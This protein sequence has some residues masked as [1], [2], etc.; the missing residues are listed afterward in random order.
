MCHNRSPAAQGDEYS[1]F[2]SASSSGPAQPPLVGALPGVV[3]PPVEPAPVAA[4]APVGVGQDVPN[5][6]TGVDHGDLVAQVM[7]G[8]AEEKNMPVQF[9][10]TCLQPRGDDRLIIDRVCKLNPARVQIGRI[11]FGESGI[12]SVNKRLLALSILIGLTLVVGVYTMLAAVPT[13]Y[14]VGRSCSNISV[15]CSVGQRRGL[16]YFPDHWSDRTLNSLFQQCCERPPVIVVSHTGIM[17]YLSSI[18]RLLS[19]NAFILGLWISGAV[20]VIVWRALPAPPCVGSFEF[21]TH[22]LACAFSQR[23]CLAES[24][25]VDYIPR[26]FIQCGEMNIPQNKKA[27]IVIG[28]I[29]AARLLCRHRDFVSTRLG[30]DLWES[31]SYRG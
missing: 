27:Q 10:V 23:P 22:I 25:V 9:S 7:E 19:G 16:F 4:I 24:D 15:A 13:T 5:D 29:Q 12:P 14:W 20:F 31:H 26:L 21:C 11:S 17:L 1:A 8:I 30:W 6:L 2:S 18:W 3:V 28:T